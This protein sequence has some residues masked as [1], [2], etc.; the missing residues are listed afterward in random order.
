MRNP[1]LKK[2]RLSLVTAVAILLA[3]LYIGL[4]AAPV[5][6]QGAWYGEYFA[7]TSLSGGPVLTR[8]DDKLDFGWGNGSPGAGVPADGFSTRWTRDE[9][10]EAGT[11]RFSYRSDD[12][13]RIWVGDIL[14][15]DDWRERQPVL[16]VVDRV[17]P[18]GTQRVRVEYFENTGG[19]TLQASW[20]RVSGGEGWRG[21]Y[22][23]N[24][25]LSGAP[26]L[27]RYDA[28]IDFD[29]KRGSPADGIP[30][31]DFSVRWTRTLGFTAGTYR[32]HSSSDDGVRIYVDGRSVV[33]AWANASLPN[34]RSGDVTLSGGQHTVVVEYYEQGG[35]A[36]AHVWW[37][38]LGSF[39]GWQGQYYDNR[40][41]RGGPAL[42]R[43]DAEINFDWGEGAPADWM[44]ADNFS[45]V[46]TRQVNLA[47]GYYRLNARSDDGVRVWLDGALVMDYWRP[48]DYQWNYADGFYLEG[49]HTLKVE[50]YEGGGSARIRFWI[51]SSSVTPSP[52]GPAPRPTAA[53][54]PAPAP[55][56]P[57]P[58]Q[59]EYYNSQDLSGSP[60]LVRSDAVLDFNWGLQ[61][62]AA[63]VNR[64]GFSVRWSGSFSFEGGRY[65][66]TTYS[67][68]GVRL[69]V[70][71]QRLIDSWRP[72]R[73]YRSATVNLSAGV[74]AVRLEYFERTGSAL[75]RL[76]WKQVGKVASLP[77]SPPVTTVPSVSY[78][79]GP[80]RLD[81]WP[82]GQY[83]TAG[84]WAA[85][86]YVQ[87]RG[88]NGQY[89]YVW[90]GQVKGGPTPGSLTFEVQSAGWKTAVVGEVSVTSAG[91]TAE[92]ELFV[93]HPR[94]P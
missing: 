51:E 2:Q 27:V 61:A 37:N 7:N 71:G 6:A 47:P 54:G 49:L 17:I 81:A 90:E 92:V 35:D 11:Y 9:W 42:V 59:G 5:A 89:T 75:A 36:S 3:A 26:V 88:G 16:T 62:P 56:L 10:F 55:G 34:N 94:C 72:M 93:P 68:D 24:R 30:A 18:R 87:G 69:Y 28:A 77:V 60:V 20:A 15:V 80:L 43:D 38:L 66:F 31:D 64:D 76:S 79:G 21:E 39:S 32:F 67:D 45:A 44:P 13:I 19:A 29:W 73:G 22:Y 33:D 58:W 84:G 14:V 41:F 83:C 48:Q 86:I 8:Y 82:V 46:W 63:G 85:K 23:N 25:N 53:P 4:P 1:S 40:E 74:H 65:T 57:G 78:A 12:G 91:Q 52:T 70:D 50:Y